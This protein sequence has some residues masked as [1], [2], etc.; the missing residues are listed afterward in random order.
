MLDMVGARTLRSRLG[1]MVGLD[2]DVRRVRPAASSTLSATLGGDGVVTVGP[3]ELS[4]QGRPG[5]GRPALDVRLR[6]P[7]SAPAPT[8]WPRHPTPFKVDATLEVTADL[9]DPLDDFEAEFRFVWTSP[10][11]VDVEPPLVGASAT[12]DLSPGGG[13]LRETLDPSAVNGTDLG[14]L[15]AGL[16]DALPRL[17]ETEARQAAER[18]PVVPMDARPTLA[19]AHDMN[20]AS[21]GLFARDPRGDVFTHDIGLIRLRPSLVRVELYRHRVERPWSDHD[22]AANWELV[23]STD[24]AAVGAGAERLWGAWLADAAPDQPT[25]PG[26]RRLR[27]WTA[28]PFVTV[29]PALGRGHQRMFGFAAPPDEPRQGDVETFLESYP[30]YLQCRGEAVPT[31]VDFADAPDP[32][33]DGKGKPDA[34]HPLRF[35]HEGLVFEA[36]G[37]V[38]L[39]PGRRRLPVARGP[40]APPGLDALRGALG[41]LERSFTRLGQPLS[42]VALAAWAGDL[43]AEAWERLRLARPDLPWGA[44]GQGRACLEVDGTL[45]V[46]FPSPVRRVRLRFCAPAGLTVAQARSRLAVERPPRTR[47]EI[48]EVRRQA[49]QKKEQPDLTTCRIPVAFTLT[50]ARDAW[51]VESVMPFNCLRFDKGARLEEI[52]YVTADETARAERA[53]AECVRNEETVPHQSDP[54]PLLDPD[55]YYRVLVYTTVG[56]TRLPADPSVPDLPRVL[57]DELYQAVM[58]ELPTAHGFLQERFFRVDGPPTSIEPYVAWTHPASQALRV[59]REDDLRI[60]FRRAGVARMYG[61]PPYQLALLVRAA[62]GTVTPSTPKWSQA[63]AATHFPD[64][65]AWL[66]H[67]GDAA[68]A[69]PPDDVLTGDRN[70]AAL[71]AGARHELLVTGGVGGPLLFEDRF[72][73]PALGAAWRVP[74]PGW[75]VTPQSDGQEGEVRRGHG[76]APHLVAGDPNWADVDVSV[77]VRASKGGA[78]GIVFRSAEGQVPGKPTYFRL[79]LDRPA[80]EARIELVSPRGVWAAPVRAFE[81]EDAV[82]V[83]ETWIRL[84]VAAVGARIRA[85]RFGTLLFDVPAFE[86]DRFPDHDLSGGPRGPRGRGEG[87]HGGSDA[88]RRRAVSR[89]AGPGSTRPRPAPAS[90]A[91]RSATRCC[92]ACRSRR[93]RTAGSTRSRRP[94]RAPRPRWR[95]CRGPRRRP[96]PWSTLPSRRV[97]RMPERRWPGSAR[98]S[99]FA[100]ASGTARGWR[101][102]A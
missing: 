51:T 85:W 81:S 16:V 64:E 20:D 82:F 46:R 102:C 14:Q 22:F 33:A 18:A 95:S 97:A 53:A 11:D 69:L 34:G 86:A 99:S 41:E 25:Q 92:F 66:A 54:P 83:P 40:L 68:P 96:R 47:A 31:C 37:P 17:A 79:V 27:L 52:C 60:R 91:S 6:L 32:G 71:A 58:G 8:F 12:S 7:G 10:S 89:P 65:D 70:G 29:R 62:D 9:P 5:S 35:T 4:G 3:E 93:R 74:A 44:W 24:D 76:G 13:A 2:P 39:Q 67:L 75:T 28:N 38:T 30:D 26:T 78:V 98:R 63:P 42:P 43:P 57:L 101:R 90:A 80:Q 48:D 1:F 84:R 59:F 55:S 19:F 87:P 72:V 36:T 56:V 21:A 15:T 50:V 49:R 100:T 94:S 73:A 23:A 88:S 45:H 61:R 77:D